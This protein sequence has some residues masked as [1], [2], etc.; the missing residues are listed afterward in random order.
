[1][2]TTHHAPVFFN[3][4]KLARRT[5]A[6]AAFTTAVLATVSSASA[7]KI[8]DVSFGAWNGGAFTDA[9]TGT[10]SHCA[11]NAEYRSGVA[12]YFSVTSKHRWSMAFSNDHWEFQR[13]RGYT[14]HYQLDDGPVIESTAIAKSKALVQVHLPASGRLL[15]RFQKGSVLKVITNR[16]AMQFTLTGAGQILSRLYKCATLHRPVLD[17]DHTSPATELSFF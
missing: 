17:R 9:H 3:S 12:L 13:G 2:N 6:A 8:A 16:K 14:V 1:M 11:A 4:A 15:S 7:E 5:I 10:F